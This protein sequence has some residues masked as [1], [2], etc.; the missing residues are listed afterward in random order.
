MYGGHVVVRDE[1]LPRGEQ[2]H[3]D[4][5]RR[6]V[7]QRA[8]GCGVVVHRI[9]AIA[10]VD[11]APPAPATSAESRWQCCANAVETRNA[12]LRGCGSSMADLGDHA[13]GTRAHHG[14]ARRQEHRF[15]DAVRDEDDGEPLPAHRPRSSASRRC[16]L[17]S[18]S[19]PNGSSISSRS[20][21]EASARA[22]DTRI[23]M[24]PESS[25]GRCIAK[26][27]SPTSASA[28]A[29]S[30][31][32]FASLDAGEIERQTH[33]GGDPRP[34]HQRRRLEDES[35]PSSRAA[36]RREVAA[37]PGERAG[38]RRDQ[39]GDQVEQ[40]RLAATRRSEQ[41]QEFAATNLEI[42]RRERARAVRIDFLGAG[43]RDDGNALGAALGRRR[44]QGR[45]LTSRTID[46]VN[47]D[48]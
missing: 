46:S 41:R 32:A 48:A 7:A 31:V 35:E 15:V 18:S 5:R 24:P 36:G 45:T 26:S 47:A 4:Q 29:A 34:G 33:V 38:A 44:N 23:C 16:R 11:D 37:P 30:R 13:A 17:N 10:R 9:A 22:I 40:R 19:A 12:S 8:R 3:R 39:P 43:D 25:R 6:R 28:A 21:F 42:D 14:D 1:S 2:R 20:G 27:E